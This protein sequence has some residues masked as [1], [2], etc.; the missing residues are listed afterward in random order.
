MLRIRVPL[1]C[2]ERGI[3]CAAPSTNGSLKGSARALL[4][5]A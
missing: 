1:G 2:P 4:F 3:Y 5:H